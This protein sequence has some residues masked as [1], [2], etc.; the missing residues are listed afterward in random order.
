MSTSHESP[1]RLPR[2]RFLQ[3]GAIVAGGAA[4]GLGLWAGSERLSRREARHPAVGA[5]PLADR[6][7]R[8]LLALAAVL[9]P[10]D[11]ASEARDLEDAVSWWS[12]GRTT[13]GPYLEIY[14]AGM[15]ELQRGARVLG[16]GA[17]GRAFAD[18]AQPDRERVVAALLEPGASPDLQALADELVHGIYL[19]TPGWRSLGYTTWPGIASPPAEYTRPPGPAA[20]PPREEGT[21]A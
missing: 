17:G 14:R 21:S 8:T 5:A 10:P 18:L 2:R 15:L 20:R 1:R 13:R 9:F 12:V 6:D 11:D 7:L 16:N 3:S 4:L 19:S